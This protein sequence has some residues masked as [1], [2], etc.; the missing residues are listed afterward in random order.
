MGGISRTGGAYDTPGDVMRRKHGNSQL[1][2]FGRGI[3]VGYIITA[4]AAAA[5]ALVMIVLGADGG[6]A[7]LPALAAAAAGSFFCG[8]TAGRSRRREG[9]KTGA[10]CGVMYIAPLIL[11]GL[12][13]GMAQGALLLVKLL[14]CLGFAM[15]GGV[16][17]VNSPE[18]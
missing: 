15:A 10:I 11:I 1:T 12:I 7:W 18:R 2:P 9:L 14:L 8:R 13:T 3:A 4:A 6:I 5:G 16:A 17:G